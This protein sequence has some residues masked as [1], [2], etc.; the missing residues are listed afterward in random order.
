MPDPGGTRAHATPATNGANL[1]SAGATAAEARADT[2]ESAE[3]H[4]AGARTRDPNAP[5]RGSSLP[6]TRVTDDMT[7]SNLRAESGA[8]CERVHRPRRGWRSRALAERRK[9]TFLEDR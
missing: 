1:R 8:N 9:A 2:A 4:R 6:P 5:A 3:E 7:G